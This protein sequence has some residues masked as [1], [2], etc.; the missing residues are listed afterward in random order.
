MTTVVS[1]S[2]APRPTSF[3]VDVVDVAMTTVPTTTKSTLLF[4]LS[5]TTAALTPAARYYSRLADYFHA[6]KQETLQPTIST[7]SPLPKQKQQHGN[8]F[9]YTGQ[10]PAKCRYNR[11]L[12]NKVVVASSVREILPDVFYAWTSLRQVTF[13]YP[14]NCKVIGSNAFYGCT[15]LRRLD[16]DT[17]PDSIEVIGS[18]GTVQ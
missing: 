6:C 4:P 9:Y 7:T 18:N 12:Y 16:E 1:S 2:V 5:S 14:S 11:L 13:E 15:G 10:G 17:L 8:T 3:E